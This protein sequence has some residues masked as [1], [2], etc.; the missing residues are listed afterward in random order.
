MVVKQLTV[1]LENRE[2][3]LV[4]VLEV[5]AENGINIIALSIADTSEYGVV[6]MMVSDPQK[7]QEVL[8]ADGISAH[9]TD[10]ICIKVSHDTG[11]LLKA[12]KVLLKGG[13]D[14][15]YMYA[16]ANGDEAS[17]VVKISDPD[18][19]IQVLSEHDL[20]VWTEEE[21]YTPYTG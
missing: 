10:V 15:A 7:G 6:R 3:R 4:H 9:L 5:L 18:K 20:E 2:G 19:A 11:S 1:F 17:A 14:V 13:V 21:A 12:L 16:F 8:K